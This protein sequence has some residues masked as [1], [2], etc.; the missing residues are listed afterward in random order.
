MYTERYELNP[1]ITQI[2]SVFKRLTCILPLLGADIKL[3]QTLGKVRHHMLRVKKKNRLY[4]FVVSWNQVRVQ[5]LRRTS[6]RGA[7]V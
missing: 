3:T 6:V 5:A 7:E 2:R 4:N 1:Y